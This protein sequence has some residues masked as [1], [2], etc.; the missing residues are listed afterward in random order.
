MKRPIIILVILVSCIFIA[1][2]SRSG[3]YK[4]PEG[5]V[6]DAETAVKIAEVVW[7]PVY[8]KDIYN[9]RPFKAALKDGVWIVTGSLPMGHLGGVPEA[10]ISKENGCVLEISHSK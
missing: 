5:M 6:P 2:E 7:L 8:G 9:K 1:A 4:P 3:D 10:R